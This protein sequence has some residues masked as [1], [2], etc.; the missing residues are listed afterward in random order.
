MFIVREYRTLSNTFE[1][2]PCYYL[3]WGFSGEVAIRRVFEVTFVP[4][5]MILDV[6]VTMVVHP[7]TS[8]DDVVDRRGHFSPRVMILGFWK[9]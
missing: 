9:D 5:V 3:A 8:H 2:F 7:Q 6:H 1:L 4:R